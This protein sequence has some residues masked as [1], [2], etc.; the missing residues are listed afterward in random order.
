MTITAK[1][2]GACNLDEHQDCRGAT[3]ECTCHEGR[4]YDPRSQ[5]WKRVYRKQTTA[6]VDH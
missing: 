1:V 3:C 6:N 2:T 5:R 4:R